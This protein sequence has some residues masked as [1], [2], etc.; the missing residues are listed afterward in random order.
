MSTTSHHPRWNSLL[1]PCLG[2][3]LL[4]FLAG[5]GGGSSAPGPDSGSPQDGGGGDG[6]D[7]A[8]SG[9]PPD[10]GSDAGTP[11]PASGQI[12][13]DACLGQTG[14]AERCTLVTNASACTAEP[15]TKLVVVFSGGEMG[16]ASGAGYNNV[17]A[18]Y[19]SHGYAA[20]CINYFDT[21]TGSGTAPY[22]DEAARI[23]LAVRQ[24]TT[25]AW[26]KAY[27]TGRDLLLEGI[28]HGATAPIILMA[29]T[30]LDDQAHWHG[31]HYTAG[32]FFDG[33]YDQVA[34]ADLLQTG[35]AGGNPCTF[36]VSYTRGL[37]RYCGPGATG[38][39][40]DLTTN[41]EAQE[42]T[43]TDVLPA[44]FAIADFRMFECG[45][46]LPACTGDI[47]PGP[48]VQQLCQRIDLSPTHTCTFGSFPSDGH[49]SC[50]ANEYDQC[51]TWFEGIMPP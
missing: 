4:T 12:V 17:L 34:T 48:P 11:P 51:R 38:A 27:W 49:L 28:S 43:I 24:A 33:S 13:I 9:L 32:C 46:A 23:D 47:I 42:D 18:G 45:S 6:G 20:V 50:H 16:C 14:I 15:C 2:V 21:S 37:E 19:A 44:T 40:C 26:A 8:D 5:C 30:N 7:G 41:A 31:S 25:G 1:P 10:G 29:R 39:T 3:A 22:V 35:A 36:P